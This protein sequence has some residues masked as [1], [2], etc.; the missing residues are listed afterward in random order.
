MCNRGRLPY[1]WVS[2]AADIHLSKRADIPNSNHLNSEVPEE[3]NDLQG[4]VPQEKDEDEWCDNRT[5]QL[6]QNK[7]LFCTETAFV[8]HCKILTNQILNCQKY[9][10]LHVIY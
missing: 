3:V 2:M 10:L 4:L 8:I 1:H 9:F 6:L 7:H 5:E